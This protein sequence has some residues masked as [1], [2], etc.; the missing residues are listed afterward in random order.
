M[1]EFPLKLLNFEILKEFS[2]KVTLEVTCTGKWS[3]VGSRSPLWWSNGH[4]LHRW[5]GH[6]ANKRSCLFSHIIQAWQCAG[7][8]VF[9]LMS[10]C[11]LGS[12]LNEKEARYSGN[13]WQQ[14]SLGWMFAGRNYSL[15]KTRIQRCVF[16]SYTNVYTGIRQ[17]EKQQNKKQQQTNKQTTCFAQQVEEIKSCN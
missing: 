17:N 2:C 13:L 11:C 12:G 9:S 1:E 16:A 7:E 14:T 3:K 4:M 5:D 15:L 6:C 10:L 8:I